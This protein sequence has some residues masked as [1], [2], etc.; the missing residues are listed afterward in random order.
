MN[1]TDGRVNISIEMLIHNKRRL[2]ISLCAVAFTVVI[3]F[4]E[5]GFFNGINDSQALLATLFNAD[6]VMMDNKNIHLNKFSKMDRSRLMQA[7]GVEGVKEAIPVYKGNVGLKNPNTGLTKIV[8]VLAFP[9]ESGALKVAGLEQ[10]KEA[11]KKL[12]TILFDRKSRRIFGD[13]RPMMDVEIN[14]RKYRIGGLFD[15]GPNFSLDGTILM[16]DSTWLEGRWAYGA[17]RVAYGLL[18]TA[19]GTDIA[20]LRQLLLDRLPSDI[21]VMTPEELRR[22]EVLHTIRAVPLGSI[23]GVGMIIGFVIGIIICYQ[24]LYNEITD[25]LPQYATLRAMGFS[26]TF[27]RRVVIQEAVWLSVLGFVPGVAVSY[28]IYAIIE[29]RTGILMFLTPGRIALILIFTISMCIV[30]G[31][32]AV[33][34]VISADPAELY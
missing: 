7:L 23:F 5:M 3:M 20:A 1:F 27:L 32:I 19:P 28:L 22:R 15:M 21:L 25:H 6:L 26:D 4:M 13:I 17:D 24:I 11:L 34:R 8:F 9:P 31:L 10:G 33:K 12:G 29:Y 16:S 30:G 14:D 18:R 2:S